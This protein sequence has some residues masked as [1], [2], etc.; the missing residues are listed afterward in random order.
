MSDEKQISPLNYILYSLTAA[1][2]LVQINPRAMEYFDLSS[3][4]FWKSFWAVALIIPVFVL[5]LVYVSDTETP[6][7]I[8]SSLIY[9]V[10]ALP[11]TAVVMY[12]FTRFLNISDH[13]SSMIIAYNWLSALT[14]NIVVIV[15]LLVITIFPAS[16]MAGI[17]IMIIR[18][19]FGGYVAWF[20]YTKS[21]RISGWLAIGV[22]IFEV[23]FNYTYQIML[24]RYID[25]DAFRAFLE[26]FNNP[27]A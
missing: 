2:K 10:T 14:F 26:Q 21:L 1:W 18:F 3:D 4:G 15:T 20:M 16:E 17:V 24:M 12:Y 13:Y 19:Y 7:P 5:N 22:L 27:P 8:V 6:Q 9:L 25:A 11:V 23:I